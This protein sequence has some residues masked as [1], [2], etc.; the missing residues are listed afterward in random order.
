MI[1]SGV[2]QNEVS[3]GKKTKTKPAAGA[4]NLKKTKPAA[5]AE[6]IKNSP[7]QAPQNLT[8]KPAAGAAKSFKN[9]GRRRRRKK[10]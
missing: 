5:G 2:S 1:L 9:P 3:F 7:P 4:E 8:K 10:I 6:K